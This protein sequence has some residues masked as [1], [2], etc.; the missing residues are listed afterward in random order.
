MTTAN[1]FQC[2][3]CQRLSLLV[4]R[5]ALNRG[6]R[7]LCGSCVQRFRKEDAKVTALVEA[8]LMAMVQTVSSR[9][10]Y[11]GLLGLGSL[12]GGQHGYCQTCGRR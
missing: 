2:D 1:R 11:G 9:P 10:H 6:Q 12:F 8:A 4:R 5:H 3:G 7:N